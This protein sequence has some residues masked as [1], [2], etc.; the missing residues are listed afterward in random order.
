VAGTAT[1]AV[2]P[3]LTNGVAYT[4]SVTP[5]N[6][7][8]SGPAATITPVYAN[9][10][11]SIG[12]TNNP[13]DLTY[14]SA[15]PFNV[16]GHDTDGDSVTMAVTSPACTPGV[17]G[18]NCLPDGLT[19]TPHNGAQAY[20]SVT[21]ADTSPAGN[22]LVTFTANDGYTTTSKQLTV[23]VNPQ[24]V[25]VAFSS[26]ATFV[27]TV[28]STGTSGVV[29]A[30]ATIKDSASD[31][32]GSLAHANPVTFALTPVGSFG[33]PATCPGTTRMSLHTL[34]ASCSFNHIPVGA[35][36]LTVATNDEYYQGQANSVLT[37]YNHFLPIVAGAG[38]VSVSG[39]RTEVAFYATNTGGLQGGMVVIQH[40]AGGDT[41]LTSTSLSSLIATSST[42]SMT[43]QGSAAV[44]NAAS[45]PFTLSVSGGVRVTLQSTPINVSGF[46]SGGTYISNQ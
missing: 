3:N 39:V 18:G 24:P 26:H 37:V 4:C 1:S 32:A 44:G 38:T 23:Q 21:G 22:Y 31:T 15:T 8:G 17:A 41:I 43:L 9:P 10:P 2:V 20:V 40:L 5:H 30:A 46:L 6:M 11:A 25:T 12:F 35:Y 7:N 14:G 36:L 28:A 42:R 27:S 19:A 34:Y 13:Q 16:T 33:T 45:N 29:T